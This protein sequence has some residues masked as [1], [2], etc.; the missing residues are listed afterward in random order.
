MTYNLTI[1]HMSKTMP[2]YHEC[3]VSNTVGN[4]YIVYKRIYYVYTHIIH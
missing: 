2:A 4:G 3:C 1:I